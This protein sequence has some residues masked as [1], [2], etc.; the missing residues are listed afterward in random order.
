MKNFTPGRRGGLRAWC[1]VGLSALVAGG[2]A[3]TGTLGDGGTN[4]GG[5]HVGPNG[6]GGNGGTFGGQGGGSV[7]GGLGGSMPPP[8]LPFEAADARTAVR[9]VK[10]LLVGLAPTDADVTTVTTMGAAGLQT[11]ID[12]WMT[13]AQYNTFFKN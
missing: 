2:A 3:C 6:A 7:L 8:P 13:D 9:K 10:N 12:T 11:L 1:C 4:G 5:G